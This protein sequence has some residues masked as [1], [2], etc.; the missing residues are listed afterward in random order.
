MWQIV[1]RL[2]GTTVKKVMLPASLGLGLTLS[3][4]CGD[5]AIQTEADSGQGS[6]EA[7]VFYPTPAYAAPMPADGG[8]LDPDG[9]QAHPRYA[10]SFEVDAGI[11]DPQA[12]YMAP[13]PEP[14]A[15]TAARYA[16]SFPKK[17]VG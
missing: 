3:A 9:P 1:A 8:I 6:A 2:L 5:R 16:A 17:D 12:D 10:A 7:G 4:G 15:G 11:G 13:F 14:D